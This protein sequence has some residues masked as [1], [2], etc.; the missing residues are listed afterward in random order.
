VGFVQGAL[1]DQHRPDG[2]VDTLV[3]CTL[4]VRRVVG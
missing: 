4:D 2:S 1:F 3:G